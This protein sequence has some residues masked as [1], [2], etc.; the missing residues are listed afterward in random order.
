[1]FEVAF[2]DAESIFVGL[3][4]RSILGPLL[5]VLYVN[6]LPTIAGKCSMLMYAD[7]TVLFHSGK[8]AAAIEK[9]F[10]KDPGSMM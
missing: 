10:N 5:F 6:D 9:S 3:P 4:Q 2:S 8:V 7:D 1:M